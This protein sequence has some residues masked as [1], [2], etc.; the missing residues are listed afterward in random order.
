MSGGEGVKGQ[1]EVSGGEGVKGQDISGDEEIDIEKT[2][3]N[4]SSD[5]D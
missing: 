1:D 4:K 5:S 3:D 2:L